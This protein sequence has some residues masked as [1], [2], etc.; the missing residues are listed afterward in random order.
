M[1]IGLKHVLIA[2]A[3]AVAIAIAALAVLFHR[4]T[5]LP[6]WYT[7]Q[8][9]DSGQPSDPQWIEAPAPGQ[10]VPEPDSPQGP[11]AGPTDRSAAQGDER[12]QRR[13]SKERLVR[14]GFHRRG[15]GDGNRVVKAS[16]AV[17]EGDE[18]EAGVVLDLSRLPKDKLSPRDAKLLR[19]AEAGFAGIMGRDVYVGVEDQPIARDGYLQLG[20]N[21]QIRVGKLRYSLPEAARKLGLP[22][23]ELRREL[24]RE[25]RR[26]E[27]RAPQAGAGG[28]E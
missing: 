8:A 6:E 19:A 28:S 2:L 1:S 4:L 10:P 7:E 15:S 20:P 26:L 21:P 3:I 9:R 23:A 16:R 17:L 14:R 25:L 11:E 22:P 13:G 24:D 18:L 27:F 5:A 12:A